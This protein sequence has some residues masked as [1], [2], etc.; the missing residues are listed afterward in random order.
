MALRATY[1]LSVINGDP[2]P[3]RNFFILLVMDLFSKKPHHGRFSFFEI[4]LFFGPP[5]TYN[6]N[7]LQLQQTTTFGL[8]ELL[9]AAKNAFLLN[10]TK[11]LIDNIFLFIQ[12]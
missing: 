4:A 2:V 5:W 9:S 10:Y 1:F 7:K 3:Y 8:L 6:Y 12:A 11:Y